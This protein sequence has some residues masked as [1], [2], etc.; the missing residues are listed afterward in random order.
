MNV[1][2]WL[3]G[4]GAYYT[5]GSTLRID[6]AAQPV[7]EPATMLLLGAGLVGLAVF[8]KRIRKRSRERI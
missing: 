1:D 7:P 5:P 4:S 3:N 8:R 6:I 2:I